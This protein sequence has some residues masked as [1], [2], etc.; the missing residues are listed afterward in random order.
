MKKY[1]ILLA[2]LLVVVGGFLGIRRIMAD[3][4]SAILNRVA[5]LVLNGKNIIQFKKILE[6]H[7]SLYDEVIGLRAKLIELEEMEEENEL[8]RIQLDVNARKEFDLE[9]V[10]LFNISYEEFSSSAFINKGMKSGIRVGMPVITGEATLVGLIDEVFET[11]SKVMLITDPRFKIR[12]LNENRERFLAIGDGKDGIQLDFVT[13]RDEFGEGELI[14]SEESETVPGFLVLGEV[15][16]VVHNDKDLFKKVR[17]RPSFE[18]VDYRS[19][20]VIRD[21]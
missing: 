11:H 6:E 10:N 7:D 14:V 16:S 20:F 13:P 19:A 8:L 18:K 4:S 12:V 21:F 1:F 3:V 2:I 17:V 15:E 5:P 9:I